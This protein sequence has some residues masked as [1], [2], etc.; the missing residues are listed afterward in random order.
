MQPLVKAP[1][2]DAGPTHVSTLDS[3]R[4]GCVENTFI[5]YDCCR[6]SAKQCLSARTQEQPGAA[7]PGRFNLCSSTDHGSSLKLDPGDKGFSAS[8]KSLRG[9]T[10]VTLVSPLS[11]RSVA[12]TS[13]EASPV[14]EIS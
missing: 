6:E 9:A 11:A 5:K 7:A 8:E 4:F 12:F 10:S 13:E 2:G 14:L 3:G 1:F